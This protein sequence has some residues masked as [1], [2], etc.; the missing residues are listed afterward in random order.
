MHSEKW[1]VKVKSSFWLLFTS[2]CKIRCLQKSQKISLNSKKVSLKSK[3]SLCRERAPESQ[4]DV[5]K[6]AKHAKRVPWKLNKAKQ[7]RKRNCYFQYRSGHRLVIGIEITT[8]SK[9]REISKFILKEFILRRLKY[10]TQSKSETHGQATK[11]AR[12]MPWHWEPMKDAINCDKLRGAVYRHWSVDFRME[13]SGWSHV[14]SSYTEFIGVW[15]EPPE[16]K[17]LSRARKRNQPRFR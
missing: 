14:Q 5:G 15:G 11:S 3:Y 8:I 9:K 7:I 17:H 12:G 10:D 16:L 4:S 1:I 13:Q 6:R 2:A